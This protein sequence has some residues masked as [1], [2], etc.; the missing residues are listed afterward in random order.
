MRF[1]A[2]FNTRRSATIEH[3]QPKAEGGTCELDNLVLCHKGCNKHLG[4]NSPAQKQRMR[5]RHS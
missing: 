1:G 5:L 4:T 2:P 3:L